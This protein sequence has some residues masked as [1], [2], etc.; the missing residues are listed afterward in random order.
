MKIIIDA[1]EQT[2]NCY[3]LTINRPNALL[4][5][6]NKTLLEHL[7]VKV[8]KQAQEV[9]IKIHNNH[10]YQI[11]QMELFNQCCIV[12]DWVEHEDDIVLDGG[13]FYLGD[14]PQDLKNNIFPIAYSWDLLNCQEK[15]E[16]NIVKYIS[17]DCVIE[18]FAT[19]KGN[20]S[21][22]A[23]TIIKNGVYISGSVTIGRNCIIGPNCYIRGV[24]SIGDNCRIGNAVE[25]KNAIIGKNANI[26]HLS[27]FGDSIAGNNV[28]LG[29][30][31]I[32]ANLRHD[33]LEIATSLNGKK[34][35]TKRKKLG[36]IIGDN[37]HTG[38]NTSVYPGRKIWPGQSTKPGEIVSK[39]IT[40]GL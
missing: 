14:N 21:V 29:A 5:V 30:G 40:F 39:D 23:G 24:T 12:N 31:F 10:I 25:I 28:G 27:Y 13:A 16:E 35:A 11:R 38:I 33:N 8:A 17:P 18:E 15:Y 6:F 19:L 1:T 2:E 7:F 22:G 37:V 20:I 32:N 4:S 9:I 26:C 3:P 36:A 34:I